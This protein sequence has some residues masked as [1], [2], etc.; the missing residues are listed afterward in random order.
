LYNSCQ[1]TLLTVKEIQS[2][3]GEKKIEADKLQEQ[4]EEF[5]KTIEAFKS[6]IHPIEI[7]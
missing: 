3:Q 4:N 7:N 2:E 6:Q 5:I 1:I